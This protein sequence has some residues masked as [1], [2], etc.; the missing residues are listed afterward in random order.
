A[1]P[2]RGR[3]PAPRA[4]GARVCAFGH[5]IREPLLSDLPL[6]NVHPSLLPRWRGAAPIERS[7]MAGDERTGVS[8]MRVTAGLDSGPVA[9]RGEVAIA[10]DDDFPALSRKLHPLRAR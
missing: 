7:I 8:V 10:P 2:P 1:G 4:Q 5:L 3:T 6:I 9:L